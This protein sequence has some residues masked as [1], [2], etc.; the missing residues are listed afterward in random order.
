[1]WTIEKR[2]IFWR[3]LFQNT[4]N[5]EKVAINVAINYQ[6]E[7]N[8]VTA[9]YI[10]RETSI[11]FV[12]LQDH[13]TTFRKF[14]HSH[15]INNEP[16]IPLSVGTFDVHVLAHVSSQTPEIEQPPCCQTGKQ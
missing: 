12:S 3:V 1:M 5:E 14:Q 8:I 2:A 6:W 4:F 11:M 9:V 15:R 16:E 10:V 7:V 13:V